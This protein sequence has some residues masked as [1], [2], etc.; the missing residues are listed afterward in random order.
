METEVKTTKSCNFTIVDVQCG[1]NR[2][3]AMSD[4]GVLSSAVSQG[5]ERA[6]SACSPWEEKVG[7]ALRAEA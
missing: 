3:E 5:L 1:D 6:S 7:A 2:G 4:P